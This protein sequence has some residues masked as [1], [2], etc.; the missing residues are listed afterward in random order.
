MACFVVPV[1]EAIVTTAAEKILKYRE[2]KL[3]ISVS[4]PE[5]ISGASGEK[6][7]KFSTKLGWLNKMLWGG[8]ALLAFEHVW[9]GEVVPFFPFLTAVQNGE[10]GEMLHEM[11]TAGVGMAVLVTVV[12]GIL[13]GVSSVMEKSALKGGKSV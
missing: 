11:A 2:E 3:S 13:V 12:W 7:I 1:V 6:K 8:S 5:E 4:K 10:T 9:H